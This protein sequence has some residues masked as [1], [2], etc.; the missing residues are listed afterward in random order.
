MV[1]LHVVRALSGSH[2]WQLTVAHFNHGLRGLSSA[3]DERLVRR[4][5]K[6]LN[7]PVL[8]ERADVQGYAKSHKLSLEMAGRQLRHAFLAHSAVRLKIPTVALAHHADD[9][10]ELFFLRLLRGSGGEG[11]AGMKWHNPSPADRRVELVRPLLDHSKDVLREYSAQNKIS[12]REDETNS[13]LDLQ[14]NR[15]RH[16]L[17]PLLKAHYQPALAKTVLRAMEI[18]GTEAQFVNDVSS[19]WLGRNPMPAKL[20]SA[21]VLPSTSFNRLPAAVQRRCVELQLAAQGIAPGFELVEN[22]RLSPAKPVNIP[23]PSRLRAIRATTG[24]VTLLREKV[25]V[26]DGF[27][28]KIDV[29]APRGE[30]VLGGSI[31]NWRIERRKGEK[32]PK[33]PAG[34]EFFDADEVGS[35]IVLRNWQPGD[36][37]QPI[38]MARAVKLQDVFTNQKVPRALRHRLIVASTVDGQIFWVEGLRISDRFKLTNGTIRRLHW[39]WQRL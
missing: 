28:R 23:G 21:S 8:V 34:I 39:R 1:L 29:T 19:Q 2:G 25:S 4:V 20:A 16:E 7:L 3:A 32:P 10:L 30:E 31:L 26:P 14:R 38:G 17:L 9:Q 13:C 6:R 27:L 33:S 18:I 11:L 12:F 5:A 35:P 22:L 36:R 37:F 24:C 15:I